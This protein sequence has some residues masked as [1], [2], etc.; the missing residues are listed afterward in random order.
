MVNIDKLLQNNRTCPKT[1]QAR[2][3]MFLPALRTSEIRTT[4]GSA[5]A[6]INRGPDRTGQFA[7]R[8]QGF[9]T[10]LQRWRDN[11][12]SGR[13]STRAK[14][15][16]T[17]LDLRLKRRFDPRPRNIDPRRNVAQGSA[18]GLSFLRQRRPPISHQIEVHNRMSK[19]STVKDNRNYFERGITPIGRIKTNLKQSVKSARSAQ[20]AFKKY[21]QL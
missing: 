7:M 20:S 4:F 21:V 2:I 8:A 19:T 15:R 14:A 13:M 17:R 6:R 11:E 3:Q 16:N 9:R 18:K 1:S 12:S 5:A 10:G